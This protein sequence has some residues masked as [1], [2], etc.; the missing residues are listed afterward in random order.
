MLCWERLHC[1]HTLKSILLCWLPGVS[2][3]TLWMHCY[4]TN[5]APDIPYDVA[6]VA[7]VVV[8][9]TIVQLVLHQGI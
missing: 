1:S 5:I 7:A 9:L 8:R 2:T 3:F 4:Q 6:P